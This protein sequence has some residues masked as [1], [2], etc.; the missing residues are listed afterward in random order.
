MLELRTL[1]KIIALIILILS[2]FIAFEYAINSESIP[3]TQRV[4]QMT[5]LTRISLDENNSYLFITCNYNFSYYGVKSQNFIAQEISTDIIQGDVLPELIYCTFNGNPYDVKKVLLK[6][7][8]SKDGKLWGFYYSVENNNFNLNPGQTLTVEISYKRKIDPQNYQSNY[9][10]FFLLPKWPNIG[11]RLEITFKN[12]KPVPPKEEFVV[13]FPQRWTHEIVVCSNIS[14]ICPTF[15]SISSKYD[16]ESNCEYTFITIDEQRIRKLYLYNETMDRYV[17]DLNSRLEPKNSE[18]INSLKQLYETQIINLQ[19][20]KKNIRNI[21]DWE[22]YFILEPNGTLLQLNKQSSESFSPAIIFK[23]PIYST[24]LSPTKVTCTLSNGKTNTAMSYPNIETLN[25]DYSSKQEFFGY[26]LDQANNNIITKAKHVDLNGSRYSIL[27]ET[28]DPT[29]LYKSRE[30]IFT[31][32][33]SIKPSYVRPEPNA[34]LNVIVQIPDNFYFEWGYPKNN[35][36][37]QENTILIYNFESKNGP[38]EELNIRISPYYK[39]IIIWLYLLNFLLA[40]VMIYIN[41]GIERELI[42]ILRN[43]NIGISGFWV[44]TYVTT[45]I[46]YPQIGLINIFLYAG[47]YLML[48]V[49]ILNYREEIIEFID[50]INNSN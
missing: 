18:Y 41:N 46:A 11:S 14:Q 20:Q 42:T 5:K 26:Y 37:Y 8:H 29:Y 31:N 3:N 16:R 34:S 23:S 4:L 21:S 17:H 44:T 47:Y 32:N 19:F 27:I 7:A 6:E 30:D 28:H 13:V 2:S 1:F 35:L 33:I 12:G 22:Y 15:D 48:S 25:E 36:I 38:F 49:I 10:N 9:Q 40:V 39:K 43:V 50:N 45:A 24:T